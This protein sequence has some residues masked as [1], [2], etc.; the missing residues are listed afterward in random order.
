M[1]LVIFVVE[2]QDIY[3]KKHNKEIIT[4]NLD[5]E[6]LADLDSKACCYFFSHVTLK[7]KSV[8]KLCS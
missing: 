6:K 3:C 2:N 7:Y 4:E 1:Q 8:A 5:W